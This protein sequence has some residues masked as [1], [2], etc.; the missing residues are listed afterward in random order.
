MVG[1]VLQRHHMWQILKFSAASMLGAVVCAF[2]DFLSLFSHGVSKVVI[3][4]LVLPAP[5]H[6]FVKIWNRHSF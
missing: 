4:E 5:L 3:H 6:S 2:L 1:G